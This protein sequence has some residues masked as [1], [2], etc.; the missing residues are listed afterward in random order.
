MKLACG[1]IGSVAG[2]TFIKAYIDSYKD[3]TPKEQDKVWTFAN[4]IPWKLSQE[5]PVHVIPRSAFYPVAWSNK[6]FWTGQQIPM[7]NSFA[8]HTWESL[9][10]ELS[11]D[12]LMKTCLAP[13]IAKIMGTPQKPSI[14]QVRSGILSFE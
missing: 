7:K 11:I 3:W 4:V 6:T 10:P 1:L 12:V 2:S 5:Y 8:V 9:H 14:V 13:E